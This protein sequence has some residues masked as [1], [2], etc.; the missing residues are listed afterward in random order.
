MKSKLR[1]TWNEYIKKYVNPIEILK[2]TEK[3]KNILEGWKSYTKKRKEKAN[4]DEKRKIVF[5][6]YTIIKMHTQQNE[7]RMKL[8]SISKRLCTTQ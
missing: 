2:R 3:K 4:E 7:Q 8:N 1:F 5:L 6:R